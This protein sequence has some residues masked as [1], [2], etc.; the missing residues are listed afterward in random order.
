MSTGGRQ[1]DSGRPL[2]S[3]D[4]YQALAAFRYALRQF[5]HFSEEAARRAG[6]TPQQYLAMIAVRGFPG[7]DRLTVS[8]LA[9]R[10]QIRHHSA[11]G[12]IDR[13]VSQGLMVRH[14]GGADRRQ[15][16]VSLTARGAEVLEPLA[17][18]HRDQL[19]RIGGDLRQILERLR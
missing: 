12:L 9:E 18:A 6:V 15:V 8:E 14:P 2:M 10:L 1:D 19:Q 13:M 16:F 7:R 4:D 17:A 11:V 3:A 5:L